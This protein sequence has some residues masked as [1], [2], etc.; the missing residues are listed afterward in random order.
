MATFHPKIGVKSIFC[1]VPIFRMKRSL[2]LYVAEINLISGKKQILPYKTCLYISSLTKIRWIMA[3][4][5]F[6]ILW[7]ENNYK[8][9]NVNQKPIYIFLHNFFKHHVKS[10]IL[11][12]F[13]AVIFGHFF[14][15]FGHYHSVSISSYSM[16]K[17]PQICDLGS[18]HDFQNS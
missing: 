12:E 10:K 1:L 16:V 6:S 9:T 17:L 7:H 11:S 14:L 5:Y 3:G 15:V 13:S 8:H 2:I 18:N 4:Y